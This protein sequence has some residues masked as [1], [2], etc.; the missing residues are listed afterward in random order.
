M[1]DEEEYSSDSDLSDDD[2]KPDTKD[3]DQLSEEESDGEPENNEN[4]SESKV[5]SRKRKASNDKSELDEIEKQTQEKKEEYDEESCK[6]RADAL[7]AN[8]LSGTDDPPAAKTLKSTQVNKSTDTV[9]KNELKTQ[10][11]KTKDEPVRKQTVKEIFE[12]A[13]EKVE[14]E[15]EVIQTDG[16][17]NE[18]GS[19][20][21]NQP[22]TKRSRIGAAGSGLNA[23][24]GQLGKKNKL[25]VLEKTKI[26]WK[27]FKK[28]EGIDEELQIH[29]KGRNGFLER[30]DF[31]ERTDLR[32]FEIEKSMRQTNRKKLN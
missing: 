9:H 2:Y 30:Q 24:L 14:V 21:S 6:A 22:Q 15:K 31:L 17:K 28:T 18:G 5:K 10:E 11:K 7:W 19:C 3:A 23:I 13:G 32:Q 26:D 8:F 25:S 29:N 16:N 12:F 1:L 4:D 20:Q 27:G